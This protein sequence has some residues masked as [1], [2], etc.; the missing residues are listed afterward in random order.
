M[1][2]LWKKDIAVCS[3]LVFDFLVAA[4]AGRYP[5]WTIHNALFLVG[6]KVAVGIGIASEIGLPIWVGI[7]LVSESTGRGLKLAEL[8]GALCWL[9]VLGYLIVSEFPVI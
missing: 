2:A 3:I 7:R 4:P 5:L 6:L 1:L 9:V 8:I